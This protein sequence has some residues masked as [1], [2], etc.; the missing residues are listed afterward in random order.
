[1]IEDVRVINFYRYVDGER[2]WR[3]EIQ[4][5]KNGEW[6]PI[7]VLVREDII[8][9]TILPGELEEEDGR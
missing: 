3:H 7:E 6:S 4:V 2:M 9:P 1:M 8:N 5:K